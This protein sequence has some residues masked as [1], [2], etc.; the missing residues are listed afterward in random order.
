MAEEAKIQ[1]ELIKRFPF[2]E[3]KIRVQRA[4]RIYAEVSF[5]KFDEV[6]KYAVKDM[7]FCI[8]CTMTGLDEG[9][10]LSFIYHI[11]RE[12]GTVLNLKTSVPKDDPV[13]K[14]ITPYFSAADIYE[15]EVM[16]LLGAKVE[17]LAPGNRY[18]LSDEWPRDQYPLRKDWKGDTSKGTEAKKDA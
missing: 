12:D 10:V 16:D 2:L 18:P 14:T 1:E 8:L 9:Q 7:N 13:I 3:N 11:A 6:F 15:R 4:R 5:E 17:G